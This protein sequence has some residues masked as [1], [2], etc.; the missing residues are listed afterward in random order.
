M[1]KSKKILFIAPLTYD[2]HKVIKEKLEKLGAEVDDFPEDTLSI[3]F[4]LTKIFNSKLHLSY[5]KLF[6][7]KILKKA[8]VNKYDFIFLI[9]GDY[10]SNVI[11]DQLKLMQK[12]AKF[13]MY[14]W[15]SIKVFNYLHLTKK[16]DKIFSF[17]RVDC[18][19]Y[20]FEY[21][22]LFYDDNFMSLSKEKTNNKSI[23][24][25]GS[26]H[27][28]RYKVLKK[29]DN[30]LTKNNIQTKFY[31][32]IPFTS[33]IKKILFNQKFKYESKYLIFIPMSKK[34]VLNLYKK[35]GFIIDI[36]NKDQDG[37]TMRSIETLGA[38][39]KLIT[40]NKSIKNDIF[41]NENDILVIDRYNIKIN[42]DFFNN[43]YSNIDYSD[44]H[45]DNWLNKI[46]TK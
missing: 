2:Y 27:G 26:L 43:K 10:L 18:K 29:I 35:S 46:L 14:Q 34:K 6:T 24:F 30:Y 39:R 22:P 11:I 19:K 3:L 21:L 12:Q 9:R 44:L 37:L 8:S 20:G 16:F 40:T 15:D 13:V 32:Y 45:I 1:F 38:G 28:D 33:F 25:I 7:D 23:L 5:K 36:Q 41:Y 17:D 42:L 4:R 31:F